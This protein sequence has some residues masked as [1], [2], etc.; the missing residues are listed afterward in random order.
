MFKIYIQL[1]IDQLLHPTTRV[2]WIEMEDGNII[3]KIQLPFRKF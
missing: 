1:I 3:K 2:E